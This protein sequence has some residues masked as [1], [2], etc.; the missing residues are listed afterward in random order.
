MHV[1]DIGEERG[2]TFTFACLLSL[3]HLGPLSLFAIM[4][5]GWHSLAHSKFILHSKSTVMVM[6]CPDTHSV[7]TA[8][9]G[10]ILSTTQVGIRVD[11]CHSPS[12]STSTHEVGHLAHVSK[13]SHIEAVDEFARGVLRAQV[14][15]VCFRR[16]F[17]HH[18]LDRLLEP[19]VL[20]LDVL[21][22][23]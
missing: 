8:P 5:K 17:L 1:V 23:A 19:Q 9:P 12:T 13:A 4:A 22:L 7:F 21:C 18:Q 2:L 3:C 20:N 6:Y 11:S 14:R 10:A 15:R 16:D